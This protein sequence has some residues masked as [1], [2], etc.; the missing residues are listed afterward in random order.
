MERMIGE[1]ERRRALQQAYNEE[2]GITP[3]SIVKSID[4]V[5]QGT[6]IADHKREPTE[7]RGWF[8]SGP[9]QLPKAAD[10]V[11]R[12]LTLDQKR[13]LVKQLRGEMLEA[14]QA[15]DF[16]KAAELRDLIMQLETEL[17]EQG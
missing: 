7:S 14:A 9:E 13:E 8:Y 16:E 1:T 6:T 15:L 4:Q 17:E 10:P 3:T 11:V 2:H 12:Y 5:K